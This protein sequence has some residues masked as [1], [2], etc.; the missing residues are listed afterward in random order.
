MELDRRKFIKFVVAGSIAASCPIDFAL[1]AEP[2]E[3]HEVVAGEHFELCHQVRDG[4]SFPAPATSARHDVAIIGGGV[5]GLTAA[6]LMRGHDFV[7][8]EKETHWGGNAYTAG[9]EGQEFATGAAFSGRGDPASHLAQEIGLEPLPID[10][11]DGTIVN[12]IYVRDTW[13][14]GLNDL[15]YPA[16]VVRGFKKFRD[17]MMRVDVK[18]RARE[19]DSMS[20]ATF[21]QGYPKELT[22]W[23]DAYGRSNWGGS[24]AETSAMVGIG[25]MRYIA[26]EGA[27]DDRVTFAG[28]LGAITKQLATVLARSHSDR[29]W[30]GATIVAVAQ[31]RGRVVVT[32]VRDGAVKSL[33]ARAAIIAIPKL[34]ARRVVAGLP[35]VQGQAMAK[36]PYAP[37]AVVNL[38]FDAPVFN[39]GYDTWC[40]GNAFTDFIVADWVIRKR[41]GYRQRNNILTCYT[42][43]PQARR[44]ELL[45]E[46]GCRRLAAQVLGDFRKL[47]PKTNA[48]PVEVHL[49]RR[50]HPM[51]ISAPRVYTE[52]IPAARRPL[53]RVFFANTDSRGPVSS[54]DGAIAAA[55]RAVADVKRLFAGGTISEIEAIRS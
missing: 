6:Y 1:A 17:A 43:L 33:E 11:P 29:M 55:H 5:S 7:L 32:Y 47:F 34:I 30:S 22:A 27:P 49:Y 16:E 39:R 24:T 23:W 38:I 53:E 19:L 37:Y 8:L 48:N 20:L 51:M 46:D 31:E 18:A 44:A 15:P 26:A 28:G 12:G 13:R 36:I 14:S 10:S 4:R 42:P 52:I 35:A 54:T 25:T 50:G 2:A 40:P 9:Y 41:P 3:P 21:L 45:S